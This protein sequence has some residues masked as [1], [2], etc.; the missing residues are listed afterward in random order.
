MK[1][2]S[3]PEKYYKE[4]YIVPSTIQITYKCPVTSKIVTTDDYH[5][6]GWEYHT[7]GGTS[8]CGVDLEIRPCSAC[9]KVHESHL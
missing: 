4:T 2:Y 8:D 9:G 1:P 7:D 3:K 5:L 6:H